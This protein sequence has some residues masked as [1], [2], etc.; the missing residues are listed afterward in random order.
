[1]DQSTSLHCGAADFARLSVEVLR[2]RRALRFNARG[3]SMH[4]LLRDG[5]TL[6]VEPLE[7]GKI[8]AGQIVLCAVKQDYV[9]VHRVICRSSSQQ[10]DH[11]LVKGDSRLRSDGWIPRE[12]IYG[13]VVSLERGDQHVNLDSILLRLLG[14]LAVIHSRWNLGQRRVFRY[15]ARL[16]RQAPLFYRYLS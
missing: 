1:M 9:V 2:S 7:K 14:R 13:R 8:R 5:D 16:L 4:P 15:I 11:Y 10:V 3:N 6:L 12:K